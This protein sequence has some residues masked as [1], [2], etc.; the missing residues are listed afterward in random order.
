MSRVLL[1]IGAL[2]SATLPAQGQGTADGRDALQLHPRELR[3]LLGAQATAPEVRAAEL[4]QAEVK[5]RTGLEV[6]IGGAPAG[7]ASLTLGTAET[8]AEARAF[9][10]GHA[11]LRSMGADAFHL[12]T[13]P[14]SQHRL[15][16]LGE[17][18]GGVVAGVGKLLR[19]CRYAPGELTMPGLSLTDT[20]RLP[21]RGIYF[22]THFFNFYHVAP[23]AEVDAVIEEFALWGGNS[24]CVWFD[25]HHFTGLEDPAAKAHLARLK[26]FGQTAHR[27][28]MQFGLTFIADEAYAGS[29]A[30]L[31][32]KPAPGSYGVEL[33]PSLPAGLALIGKWQAEELDAFGPVDFIW[34]WPYDQGGCA[35]EQCAPWGGNGFLKASEQLA[36]LFHQRNPEGK[37]WLSTWY[38]DYIAGDLGEYPALFR[39]ISEHKPA[40]F[41]GMIGGAGGEAVPAPLL[42]RP[43]ADRYPLAWFPEIS[44]WGMQPWGGY[45]ANPLPG[46]FTRLQDKLRGRIQG[47]WPYSE[48]IY[49]D[50][51]KWL[52]CRFFWSPDTPSEDVL[53]EYASYYLSPETASDGVRLFQ[54]LEQTHPHNNWY[55]HHLERAEDAWTLAQS[56]DARLP[57]WTRES[58]RWRLLHLRAE[59][60][61]LLVTKGYRTPEG[62]EALRPLCDELVA[63][64]HAQDSFIRPPAFPV[65]RTDAEQLALGR[66]VKV[67]STSP[68]YAG[69]EQM[70]TDGVY[71][72]EDGQNFWVHDLRKEKTAWVQVD[73]G[74]PVAV[75]EVRL[76]YRGIRRQFWFVPTSLR[77]EVSEDGERFE[78]AGESSRVPQE[79]AAYSPKLWAY[80][81]GKTGRYLRIHLG[82]SQHVEEPYAGTL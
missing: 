50:L 39:F 44:M 15:F 81:I 38:L 70:L 22:A 10:E 82:Q 62:Q 26:H 40:W 9:R 34:T 7:E 30:E 32:P 21:V 46:L 37:V 36:G 53:A 75:K 63:L 25:M 16:V 23:L 52:W 72:E 13:V 33:C 45:G 67:S 28:G 60:D 51:N 65:A 19:A 77:F 48:G 80:P 47:G 20:P 2:L 66:P 11:E 68:E 43:E 54:L 4:F 57:A 27:V 29:P 59:I 58:W 3:I 1:G 31:R 79:G 17:S 73:L 5:R 56:I 41:E 55:A 61:H 24:L 8:C 42:N 6:P 76:Q 74:K 69:C 35:C 64:Y 12:A 14:D 49:E 71:A 18:P 78:D